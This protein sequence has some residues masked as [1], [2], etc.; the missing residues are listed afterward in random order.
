MPRSSG[1]GRSGGFGRSSG[2]RYSGGRGYSSYRPSSNTRYSST[3]K[4]S[5]SF[6]QTTPV[7]TGQGMGLGGAIATGMAFGTGS[8]IAHNLIGGMTQRGSPSESGQIANISDSL[9]SEAMNTQKPIDQSPCNFFNNK[10]ID[11]LRQ[12]Q[13]EISICQAYF[14]DLIS[15]EKN[16]I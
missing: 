13:N 15:C 6:G 14:N 1:G 2:G 7:R 12:N 4:P 5:Q 16:L 9:P 11:C 10:F 3:S 8:A